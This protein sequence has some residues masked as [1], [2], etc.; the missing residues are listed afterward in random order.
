MF[1]ETNQFFTNRIE[2][3]L[4]TNLPQFSQRNDICP[5][6]PDD[7]SGSKRRACPNSFDR[8]V[9]F[10]RYND[11]HPKR[12]PNGRVLPGSQ[13][14]FEFLLSRKQLFTGMAEDCAPSPL[15]KGI[16]FSS[17]T[18]ALIHLMIPSGSMGRFRC[19]SSSHGLHGVSRKIVECS[20]STLYSAFSRTQT[21]N[22]PASRWDQRSMA[23]RCGTLLE[24][25]PVQLGTPP[26][27]GRSH[28]RPCGDSRGGANE[29]PVGAPHSASSTSLP[30][31][32][33]LHF[34]ATLGLTNE[35]E[36]LISRGADVNDKGSQER[37][38]WPTWLRELIQR[39]TT[40]HMLTLRPSCWR[41][42]PGGRPG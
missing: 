13:S 36:L 20:R 39:T 34:A 2:A 24:T 40:R 5:G 16:F 42:A 26:G 6:A 29:H 17:W 35:V 31:P 21:S 11:V 8:S 33:L 37:R 27:C 15:M 30:D 23:A 7:F 10:R 3:V 22:S 41:M 14:M 1:N 38:R 4:T 25:N 28:I 32:T 19:G 9:Q 12:G 18:R